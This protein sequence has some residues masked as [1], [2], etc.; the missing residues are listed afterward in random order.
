MTD[1]LIRAQMAEIKRL[2]EE[3]D[4]MK[5]ARGPVEYYPPPQGS[6]QDG[7]ADA[8]QGHLYISDNTLASMKQPGCYRRR[9]S[10]GGSGEPLTMAQRTRAG[11]PLGNYD[12]YAA[13]GGDPGGNG[14]FDYGALERASANFFLRR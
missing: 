9:R 10:Y 11:I 5:A 14:S 7:Y 12:G 3:L 8:P 2:R 13:R 4:A 1:E 6:D